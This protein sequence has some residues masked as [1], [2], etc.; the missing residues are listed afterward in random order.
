MNKTITIL[1]DNGHGKETAGKRSPKWPDGSQLFEWDYNRRVVDAIITKLQD[2]E[3]DS[4]KLVPE[5][6]DISLSTRAARANKICKNTRCILISVHCNAGG[7]T[8]WEVFST[9]NKNNS[10]KLAEVFVETFKNNFP[11]EKCRGHKESNFTLLYKA[12]CPCVLTEN[13]FMDTE[14][15]CKLLL[16]DEGFNKVV[17]LHVDSI[18]KYIEKYG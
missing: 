12:N 17:D 1:L 11:D 18:V 2:L 6:T 14:K 9:K 4:V 13:F 8:G 10:D 5:D 3:I 7:G 16:S 15:D